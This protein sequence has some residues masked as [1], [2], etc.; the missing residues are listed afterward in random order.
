[1]LAIHLFEEVIVTR[2][3]SEMEEMTALLEVKMS[4]EDISRHIVRIR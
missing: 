4:I 1:M 2:L 3:E